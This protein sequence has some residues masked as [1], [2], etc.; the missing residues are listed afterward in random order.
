VLGVAF[1][2]LIV[3][4]A[5]FVAAMARFKRDRLILD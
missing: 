5:L 4:A 3:D 1:I 2:L